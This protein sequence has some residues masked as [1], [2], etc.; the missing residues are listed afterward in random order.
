MPFRSTANRNTDGDGA[1]RP[2]LVRK[3]QTFHWIRWREITTA[4]LLMR[5]TMAQQCQS[6][7]K[8]LLAPNRREPGLFITR[9]PGRAVVMPYFGKS[10][11]GEIGAPGLEIEKAAIATVAQPFLV[12]PA[13]IRREKDASGAQ[14]C[15]EFAQYPRQLLTRNVEQRSVCKHAVEMGLGQCHRKKILMKNFA[16]GIGARHCHEFLRPVQ[17]HCVMS[18][19]AKMV[20]IPTRSTTQVKDGVRRITLNRVQERCVVLADIVIPC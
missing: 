18:Q 8:L 9:Q 15:V 19:C 1:R 14:G 3:R 12:V 13:W 17:A 10:R 2:R 7:Q 20:E 4:T 6:S 5:Q 11:G 16:P